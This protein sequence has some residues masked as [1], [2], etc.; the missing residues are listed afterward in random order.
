MIYASSSVTAG[1]PPEKLWRI[2]KNLL[3]SEKQGKFIV[4][5]SISDKTENS[6]TRQV[7]LSDGT[8]V[9][10]IVTFIDS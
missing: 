3:K 7:M 9:K 5:C 4:G 1:A 8:E 6:F 10:E 2:I